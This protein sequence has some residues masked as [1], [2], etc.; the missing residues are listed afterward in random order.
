MFDK[1]RNKKF[2]QA[3]VLLFISQG[4]WAFQDPTQPFGASRPKA[5]KSSLKLESVLFS[6]ER[7]IAVING[8]SYQQ[9]DRVGDA[10][11][12]LVNKR[13]VVLKKG[14]QKTTLKLFKE[15]VSK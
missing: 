4:S 9:G 15:I 10:V 7:R 6:G 1:G 12:S 14:D 8:K 11:L 5:Q 3:L 13:S 2:L